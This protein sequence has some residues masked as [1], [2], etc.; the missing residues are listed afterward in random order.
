MGF[1]IEGSNTE[2]T[3]SRT[4]IQQV[5]GAFPTAQVG[6]NIV[7]EG[8]YAGKSGDA[9]HGNDFYRNTSQAG[10]TDLRNGRFSRQIVMGSKIKFAKKNCR[11]FSIRNKLKIA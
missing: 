1:Y 10:T 3:H 5:L 4:A 8:E 2:E 6:K 9:C 11:S 7:P